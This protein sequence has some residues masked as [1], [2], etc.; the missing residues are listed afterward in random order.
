MGRV[1]DERLRDLHHRVHRDSSSISWLLATEARKIST[2]HQR[3]KRSAGAPACG[4]SVVEI[5]VVIES[6]LDTRYAMRYDLP[7][8][9]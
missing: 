6:G 2:D 4:P 8:V 5:N 1:L 3:S 9:R 7:L